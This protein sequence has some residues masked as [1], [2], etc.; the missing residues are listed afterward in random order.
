M[1]KAAVILCGGRSSRMGRSKAWLPWKGKPM[2]QHIV[3]TLEPVVDEVIAVSAAD[4][5]L[6]TTS[7]RIVVDAE[8]DL[9][10]LAG[11]AAGLAHANA[12]LAFVTGTDN[13]FLTPTFIEKLFTYGRPVAPE[14]DSVIQTLAAVYS[15]AGAP[16]ASALLKSGRR[17]PLDLLEALNFHKLSEPEVAEPDAVRSLNHPA[18]YLA[19]VRQVEPGAQV[20]VELLGRAR[21]Q[22]GRR[23]EQH[24]VDTLQN[25]LLALEP[26]L[27]LL[28][29]GELRSEFRISI[30]G[31]FF[32]RDPSIPIGPGEHV[33]IL[34]GTAG[35]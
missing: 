34:D 8:P 2:L 4:T 5:E 30:D 31:R 27:E 7:A 18:D 15:A 21:A 22:L 23:E 33:I 19:A 9:G 25:I 10:P 20:T 29:G 6:P 3:H 32:S 24:P 13:P 12:D 14:L 17:R 16:L 35:G 11:I 28:D 1:R 26:E